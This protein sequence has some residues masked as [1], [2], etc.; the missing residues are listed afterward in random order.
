ME[1]LCN[2]KIRINNND[3]IVVLDALNNAG[4]LTAKAIEHI[5]FDNTSV[6]DIAR[7][8]SELAK[9]NRRKSQH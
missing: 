6:W 4:E 9:I 5:H 1:F 7:I 3:S 8:R 2:C